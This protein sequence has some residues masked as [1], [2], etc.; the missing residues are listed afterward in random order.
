MRIHLA[1]AFSACSLVGVAASGCAHNRSTSEPTIAGR[2]TKP[3]IGMPEYMVSRQ[4]GPLGPA[5]RSSDEV[6][7]AGTAWEPTRDALDAVRLSLARVDAAAVELRDPEAAVEDRRGE[8]QNVA[9]GVADKDPRD[10]ML[11]LRD[12]ADRVAN[13]V[14]V[15]PDLVSEAE[16]LQEVARR[17]PTA[18]GLNRQRLINRIGE[19]TDLIRVQIA[20]TS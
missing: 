5:G 11:T 17:L 12:S 4:P 15:R 6:P 1:I 8:R 16:E 7:V 2:S 14:K 20:A 10:P 19:L 3:F 18:K 13:V 9:G